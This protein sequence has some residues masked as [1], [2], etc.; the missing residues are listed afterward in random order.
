MYLLWLR[1]AAILYAAASVAVFP[2]VL[3]GIRP[4]AQELRPPGRNGFLL[5]LCLGGRDAGAGA[6]LDAG[7]RPRDRVAAGA[8]GGGAVLSGLVALRRYLPWYLC[9][10]GNL[11]PGFCARAGAGSLH[12]SLAK[13]CG[14]AGW[15]RTL[16][17]CCLPMWRSASAC[18]PRCSTWSRNGAS[19]A[20]PRPGRISWW[21]PLG[22]AAAAGHAGAHLARHAGVRLSLHDGGPGDRL[23]AGAGDALGAAY[24]ADPKVIASFISWAV[25]VLLLL[26]RRTA[27][28][29]GRKAAYLS[30][31]V[32]AGDDGRL[33]RQP[34]QPRAQ[35]RSAMTLALIGVNHKTA[36]IELRERIAISREDLPETTRA[37]AAMP[38]VMRV[39]D[40]LH[41]QPRGAAGRGRVAGL[42]R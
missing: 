6:S 33:G 39:H 28:L 42:H 38:G 19:R 23:G 3:Y 10:A 25:Y 22:L 30:G 11:L 24:F 21:A 17:R 12:V 9:L 5:P 2:A 29:R 26:V 7:D 41:L 40:R 20:S 4:L 35:V 8:C 37:L 16:P 13:A 18:W 31:A 36:P 32:L 15:W 14:Q 34:L 27:G 1:V